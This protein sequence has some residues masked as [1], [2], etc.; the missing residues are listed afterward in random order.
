[1]FFI[2]SIFLSSCATVSFHESAEYDQERA[3]RIINQL[4]SDTLLIAYPTYQEKERIV[5]SAL[6]KFPDSKKQLL[7]D[8]ERLEKERET[9]LAF[10]KKAFKENFTFCHY[11][12]IPD[13]L[14]LSFEAGESGP[15]FLGETAALD[16]SIT[17]QNKKPF[18][19]LHRKDTEWDLRIKN[20]LLPNPFPNR[21]A[22]RNGLLWILGI[23][24]FGTVITKVSIA[25][26]RRFEKFHNNPTRS[27]RY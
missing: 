10:I 13:S 6:A 21:I 4:K 9:N 24:D 23:E 11:L 14:V 27:V 7:T 8:L 1:M 20:D 3:A 5:K 16:P 19:V 15:F 25:L 22:Y 26:Q 12:L 18:K 2:G 17:F